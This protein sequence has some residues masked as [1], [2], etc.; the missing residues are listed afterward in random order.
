MWRTGCQNRA[1]CHVR[2]GYQIGK[3]ASRQPPPV[4][5]LGFCG[6]LPP[7]VAKPVTLKI[8][9]VM[10]TRLYLLYRALRQLGEVLND[11]A[12]EEGVDFLMK[13]AREAQPS[14]NLLVVI[15]GLVIPQFFLQGG[16][17]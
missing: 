3:K 4:T 1:N 15:A 7:S 16:D 2:S 10:P 14:A 12:G 9:M 6:K 17:T 13:T 5:R 8:M 11:G